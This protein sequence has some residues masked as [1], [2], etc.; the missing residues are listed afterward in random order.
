[1]TSYQKLKHKNAELLRQID[2]LCNKPASMEA[3]QIRMHY[4]MRARMEYQLWVGNETK[5]QYDG[6][7]SRLI[8]E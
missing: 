4:D 5:N 7:I 1:M 6:I 3:I 8:N 2:I